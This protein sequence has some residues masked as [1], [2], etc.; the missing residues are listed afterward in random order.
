M[1]EA[2]S[3]HPP[4][5][6]VIV[7]I[8]PSG[9]G[10]STLARAL[11]AHLGWNFVEGDEHH[12]PGNLQKLS[13]GVPLSGADRKPFLDSIGRTVAASE[14]P[15]I[16]SCSALQRGHREQLRSFAEDILFVWAD[17]PTDELERRMRGRPAHFMPP[18]L[19]ADQLDT[20]EP[21]APPEC[22][23]RIDGTLPT[24]WQVAQ[25]E[26]HLATLL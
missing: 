2:L 12:S 25:I 9:S 24:A 20:F 21:P 26:Q 10:K 11:A 7:L 13:A 18:S 16:V 6:S 23:I 5:H 15:V 22:F 4:S 1:G 19:L 8:G 3:E 14:E 17:V